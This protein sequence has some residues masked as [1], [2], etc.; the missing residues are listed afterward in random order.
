VARNEDREQDEDGEVGDE[1]ELLF[2][3]PLG[4]QDVP[5][6]RQAVIQAAGDC[7]GHDLGGYG[8]ACRVRAL[9]I[10]LAQNP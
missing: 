6:P 5:D 1:R 7:R 3:V 10:S 8:E 2:G 9:V 4:A